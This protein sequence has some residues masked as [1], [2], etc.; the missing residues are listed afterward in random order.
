M[1]LFITETLKQKKY[2]KNL[3]L[4]RSSGSFGDN[5]LW[6]DIKTKRQRA[7]LKTD[8]KVAIAEQS[9][10]LVESFVRKLDTDLAV[11]ENI[12]RGSGEFEALGAE[13]GKRISF[14]STMITL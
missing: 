9:L 10:E 14:Y 2:I 5:D 8:E 13:P 12:L 6:E 1:L 7:K 11:F 4:K 3:I